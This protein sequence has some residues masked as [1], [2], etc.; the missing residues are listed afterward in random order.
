MIEKNVR[1]QEDDFSLIK[2]ASKLDH[3]T[4]NSFLV[5]AGIVYAKEILKTNERNNP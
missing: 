4:P 3:R 5:K 2:E 1:I